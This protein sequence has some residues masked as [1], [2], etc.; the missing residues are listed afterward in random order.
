MWSGSGVSQEGQL[1][2]GLISWDEH[3]RVVVLVLN[4]S[5]EDGQ[6]VFLGERAALRGA[7]GSK[8]RQQG[9]QEGGM[10]HRDSLYAHFTS[11]LRA[12][13]TASVIWAKT[14]SLAV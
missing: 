7:C 4:V 2:L 12:V 3:S 9:N 8:Q 10:F 5:V 13:V 14:S 1:Q 6:A 11:W